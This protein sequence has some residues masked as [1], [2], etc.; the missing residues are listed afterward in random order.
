MLQAGIGRD[1]QARTRLVVGVRCL[2]ANLHRA[3]RRPADR[4]QKCNGGNGPALCE[5]ESERAGGSGRQTRDPDHPTA[6]AHRNYERRR[7]I[8]R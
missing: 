1:L 2:Q 8:P 6:R 5:H 7:I 3:H 4:T